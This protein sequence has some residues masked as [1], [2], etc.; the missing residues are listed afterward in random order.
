MAGDL[1]FVTVPHEIF[2]ID[3]LSVLFVK[4]VLL[5]DVNLFVLCT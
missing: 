5:F 2:Y 1:E 4:K 3:L